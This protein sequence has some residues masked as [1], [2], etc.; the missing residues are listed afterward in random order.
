MDPGA[1]AHNG[2]YVV[3]VLHDSI[4]DLAKKVPVDTA[5]LQRP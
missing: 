3:Q 4:Q 2:R 5:R 1:F